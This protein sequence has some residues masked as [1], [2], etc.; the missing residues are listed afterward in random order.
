VA[1]DVIGITLGGVESGMSS[2]QQVPFNERSISNW[3]IS[4]AYHFT[5]AQFDDHIPGDSSSEVRQ[6]ISKCFVIC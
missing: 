5:V 6:Q 2:P 3:F 4:R 1:N